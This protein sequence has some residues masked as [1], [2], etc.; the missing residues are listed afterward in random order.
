M[1]KI[2]FLLLIFTVVIGSSQAFAAPS[3]WAVSEVESA[4]ENNL[5]PVNLL[6]DYQTQITREEFS[7]MA[8]MLYEALSGEIAR[9]QFQNP[10]TD[11][12]NPEVLKAYDLGIVKGFGDGTFRPDRTIT[13]EEIAALL[14]RTHTQ[15]VFQTGPK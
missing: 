4:R 7:E 6:N 8:V 10:F 1:R 15:L 9:N 11:T 12:S 13:R 14:F 2:L 3:N 5:V